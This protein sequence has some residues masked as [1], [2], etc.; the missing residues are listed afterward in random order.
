MAPDR[1]GEEEAG[2]ASAW[3]G[4]VARTREVIPLTHIDDHCRDEILLERIR[5]GDVDAFDVLYDRYATRL[6]S[7]LVRRL[8]DRA[9]AEDM[10][11]DIFLT[12][13]RRGDIEAR[14]GSLKSWLFTVARNRTVSHHRTLSR[15]ARSAGE[16]EVGIAAPRL[17]P[18]VVAGHRQ[19]VAD[20]QLALQELPTEQQEV[21]MLKQ[22]GGLTY[23]EIADMQGVPEGTVKSRLHLA[24]KSL[25]RA[26][27]EP[28]ENEPC[29][30]K[31]LRAP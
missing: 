3:P 1:S 22:L 8:G 14:G 27:A 11:Q 9:T 5:R 25:R 29:A 24:L 13:L 17:S 4:G 18:D 23:R 21:V 2:G 6:F 20:L 15:Q 30:V 16:V 10:I 26:M 19:D 7:F 28:M 31:T 12:V